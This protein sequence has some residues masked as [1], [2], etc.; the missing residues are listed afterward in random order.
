M[1]FVQKTAEE[2]DPPVDWKELHYVFEIRMVESETV[3]LRNFL[4][5]LPAIV[6]AL[7]ENLE[8]ASTVD[9]SLAKQQGWLRQLQQFKFVVH[10]LL[11][12][13]QDGVLRTF[14]QRTQSDTAYAL[15][16][17][18]YKEKL[19]QGLKSYQA[20][21][22]GPEILRNLSQLKSGKF[23]GMALLGT[24]S[25]EDE[26]VANDDWEEGGTLEVEAVVGKRPRG[27]GYQ[28]LV[29]WL[30]WDNSS[31]DFTWEAKS[32]C[33]KCPQL[34]KQ[35]EDLPER[36]LKE[37]P[38]G[39][40]VV[41]DIPAYLLRLAQA[42]SRESRVEARDEVMRPEVETDVCGE[43]VVRRIRQYQRE[44]V[45]LLVANADGRLPIPDI[46]FKF[47]ECLDFRRMLMCEQRDGADG[48]VYTWGGSALRWIVNEKLPH[49]D[50]ERVV[51]QA[52]A[53]RIYIKEHQ[54]QWMVDTLDDADV[55]IGSELQLSAVY[56]TL[57]TNNV[58]QPALP[59][60][61]FLTVLDYSIAY[62]FTQ[63]DTERLGRVMNLM[64]TAAR[65]S[66]GDINF[67]ASV[68][69]TYNA[70]PIGEINFKRLLKRF[71]KHHRLAVMANPGTREKQVLK[72]HS[73]MHKNTFI[74]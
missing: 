51:A 9:V 40:T 15:Q 35:Y 47:R 39:G 1:R 73:A 53:V 19:L 71:K 59:P 13:D 58:I 57:F 27:R 23:A 28:L 52:T 18:G 64:K 30:G 69:V 22:F 37:H 26:I 48:P 43:N 21:A 60:R 49:L 29:K 7:K 70:P 12:L 74:S 45:G 20:G 66:L 68:Y 16:I 33:R 41:C 24:P 54:Q 36:E 61:D 44:M 46:V 11:M 38:D 10:C 31:T 72:R 5:D 34:V 50:V 25:Q 62:R 65:S 67:S 55:V 6:K 4:V 32:S 8:E 17:P 3:A 63:C 42:R 14:S 56:H 2:M